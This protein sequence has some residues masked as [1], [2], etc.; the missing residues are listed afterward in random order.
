MRQLQMQ[1]IKDR[2]ASYGTNGGMH[3]NEDG[4][5]ILEDKTDGGGRTLTVKYGL[6][7]LMGEKQERR[8]SFKTLVDIEMAQKAEFTGKINIPELNMSVYVSQIVM[9]RSETEKVRVD[10]DIT[11]LPTTNVCFDADFNLSSHIPGW[12]WRNAQDYYFATVHYRTGADGKSEYILDIDKM[13]RLM[14]ILC[15]EPWVHDVVSIYEYGVK[16]V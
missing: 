15:P 13:P 2:A 11:K 5:Q 7:K 1:E 3:L 10:D 8:V 14:K 12:F 16:K 4:N 9:L 6:I